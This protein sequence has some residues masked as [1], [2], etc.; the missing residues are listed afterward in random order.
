LGVAGARNP[1]I[2]LLICEGP[3]AATVEADL[4]AETAVQLGGSIHV[5]TASQVLRDGLPGW[6]D[7]STRLI[8]FDAWLPDL[9]AALDRH[10]AALVQDGGQL[11]LLADEKSAERLLST[12]PNL[13]SRLTDVFQ[14]VPDD[15]SGG[16]PA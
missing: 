10:S 11:L 9:V 8:Y 7:G 14:I 1:A 2:Y 5:N 13:R 15:L 4:L 3:A 12:A 16:L 6:Q